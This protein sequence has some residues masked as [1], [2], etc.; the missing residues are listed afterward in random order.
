MIEAKAIDKSRP[1][2]RD[3]K[4]HLRNYCTS[5]LGPRQIVRFSEK[6]LDKVQNVVKG[7]CFINEP[8]SRHTT[9]RIGGNVGLFIEPRDGE[10]LKNILKEIKANDL[11]WKVIG[12]GSNI[13]AGEHNLPDVVIKLVNFNSLSVD[14]NTIRA[15]SGAALA[16]LIGFAIENGLSGL[17][18]LAGIPALA[19]GA[20]KGNAGAQG[21]SISDVLKSIDVM[22][23]DGNMRNIPRDKI[24]FN[25]RKS[26]IS[27]NIVILNGFFDLVKGDKDAMQDLVKAY[28]NK[29]NKTIPAEPNAGCVFKNPPK[30]GA[31]E[32]I[33]KAG[34]KGF[35]Y[36]RAMVSYTHANIIVN[37]GGADSNDVSYVMKHVQDT[38]YEKAGIILE[39]EILYWGK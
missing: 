7:V 16:K 15:G 34:L 37:L 28:I 36:G 13:L 20:I 31:G 27:N 39:P 26:D 9:F 38:I 19:G 23:V 18:F 32:L 14:G 2:R 30:I 4:F 22:D 3:I 12:N 1:F 33:E 10:D 24:L 21:K 11:T 5:S 8:L 25:Y 6:G 29:R 35:T 17:G